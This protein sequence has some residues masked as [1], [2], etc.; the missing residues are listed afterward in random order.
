MVKGTYTQKAAS[1]SCDA[2]A[3][4]HILIDNTFYYHTQVIYLSSLH[5]IP[6][7]SDNCVY[8]TNIKNY[9]KKNASL[10]TPNYSNVYKQWTDTVVRDW[11]CEICQ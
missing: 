8:K 3:V 6:K 1:M 7:L 11:I 2:K 10:L 9:L 4:K 5:I